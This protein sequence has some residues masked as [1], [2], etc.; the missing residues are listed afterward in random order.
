MYRFFL[1]IPLFMI[2]TGCAH[3]QKMQTENLL[4]KYRH[5]KSA[6]DEAELYML[7]ENGTADEV[8][9]FLREH[10]EISNRSITKAL[11]ISAMENDKEVLQIFI[12]TGGDIEDNEGTLLLPEEERSSDSDHFSNTPF[13]DAVVNRKYENAEL[14]L[15]YGADVNVIGFEWHTALHY[16]VSDDNLYF[17]KL[18]MSYGADPK[19]KD[20]SIQT[21]C[22][23]VKDTSFNI[24]N[25]KSKLKIMNYC[26]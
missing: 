22:D 3:P 9:L 17:L 2:L 15:R 20:V 11:H 10:P 14:L 5:A 23:I 8:R 24:S 21:P 12:N 7:A 16:V 19:M 1:L 6:A 25:R 13:Y 26:R 18:L 4:D